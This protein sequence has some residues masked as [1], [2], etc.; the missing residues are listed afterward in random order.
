[1]SINMTTF[2]RYVYELSS[3]FVV[4]L[5]AKMIPTMRFNCLEIIIVVFFLY[6]LLVSIL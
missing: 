2:Y 5:H 4:P 6:K 3:I 1:M